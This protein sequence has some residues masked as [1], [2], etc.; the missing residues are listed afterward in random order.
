MCLGKA[1]AWTVK[2]AAEGS[3]KIILSDKT[4]FCSLWKTVL[5][6]EAIAWETKVEW[7]KDIK[8]VDNYFKRFFVCLFYKEKR[9]KV[10]QQKWVVAGEN[11]V[12]FWDGKYFSKCWWAGARK[13][14]AWIG[15]IDE[16][17]SEIPQGIWG[18]RVVANL[19]HREEN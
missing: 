11:V 9:E 5:Y 16:W 12:V 17:P 4:I 7:G 19:E 13:A 15:D 3:S 8:H 10:E 1:G 18:V 6:D 2:N 14:E